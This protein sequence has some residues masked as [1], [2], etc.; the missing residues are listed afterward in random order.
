[1]ILYGDVVLS[2]D[3]ALYGDALDRAFGHYSPLQTFD[4][5]DVPLLFVQDARYAETRKLPDIYAGWYCDVAHGVV[6][7]R[8]RGTDD[9]F[10]VYARSMRNALLLPLS[11]GESLRD[12]WE[13]WG[14]PEAER[15]IKERERRVRRAVEYG[16]PS[17]ETADL[18]AEVEAKCGEGRKEGRQVAFR[19]PWHQD[20]HPSL[21]VDPVKRTWFC[22]PCNKGGGVVA[23]RRANGQ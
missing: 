3:D 11:F 8:W 13:A 9:Q 1:M 20:G 22:W 18:L 14:L 15:R 4:P 21:K 23:W 19:C 16:N 12:L 2:L 6:Q 17:W 10:A 5:A 7:P